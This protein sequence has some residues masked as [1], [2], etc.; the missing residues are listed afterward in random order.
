MKEFTWKSRRLGFM[1]HQYGEAA[2]RWKDETHDDRCGFVNLYNRMVQ[3]LE[4][5]PDEPDLYLRNALDEKLTRDW[6]T[7]DEIMMRFDGR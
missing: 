2:K 6:K 7:L 5:L 4:T 3:A 1:D